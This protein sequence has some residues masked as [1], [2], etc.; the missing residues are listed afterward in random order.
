MNQ[1]QTLNQAKLD[2]LLGKMVVELGAAANAALVL[3]GEKLGLFRALA[4]FGPINS[5]GLARATKTHERYVREWLAAQAASGF[6][7]YDAATETF[8]LSPEQAAVFADEDSPVN[9][10]GGFYSLAAVFADEPRL[11]EA[12]KTGKGIGWGEHCSCLFC[13]T[14]RFF[15][16]GYKAHLVSEWL[17]ALDGVVERLSA[18][19][20][21][22]DVGCG[23]GASTTIMASAF[24]NS[25]FSGFDFHAP[26]IETARQKAEGLANIDFS[27]ARAQDFGAGKYDLVTIFDALHDMGDPAGAAAH[28]RS[29][30]KD[31]GTLMIV[32][33]LAGDRLQD[34]LH[35]VGRVYYAFSTA[36]C[37][38]A[39]LGQE[40]GTALGAQ[41]GEKRLKGILQAVG[42]SRVRRAIETP[43]NMVLEA[44]P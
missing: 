40:V 26:S 35:P 27:V 7:E 44:R 43:F 28:I 34:N 19:A 9:M 30:L 1:Q 37:V 4:E 16:P 5:D 11:T 13:G 33:P 18:G 38:P 3:L 29:Q 25:Q 24:A 8:A 22:A 21:V 12:F 17:P 42:F 39:S 36:I 23:H 6:I 32:E 31:D 10:A 14:E 15:R 41:A 2:A 20:R